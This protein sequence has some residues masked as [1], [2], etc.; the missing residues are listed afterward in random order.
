MSTLTIE[1]LVNNY[2]IP[3]NPITLEDA[4]EPLKYELL[5]SSDLKVDSEYQRLISAIAIQGYGELNRDLLATTLVSRR[6][7]SLG[8]WAG[9]FI[10][11]GQH[12]AIMHYVS[13]IETDDESTRLPCQVKVWS[14]GM[15]LE[16]IR[17]GEAKLFIKHNSERKNPTKVDIYRSG[18]LFGDPEALN[19][20]TILKNLNLVI[21]GFGS[22]EDDAI[23]L[24][25]PNP[26]FRCVL[27]DL[28]TNTMKK[29][30]TLLWMQKALK[31][32]K[33]TYFCDQN[34]DTFIHGQ[35]LR[36]FLLVTMFA[37]L[38]LTNGKQKKFKKF[39]DYKLLENYNSS[40]LIKNHGGFAGPRYI[41]HDRIID[42]Y[43]TIQ[44]NTIGKG[45]M[46]IGP[47][48]LL[49]AINVDEIFIH[50]DLL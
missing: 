12:K 50:P 26:F 35:V 41:L 33:N 2:K 8:D 25:V 14:E 47:E 32:Y 44:K 10:F 24:K 36:T 17:H 42:T 4:G 16:E 31:Q 40:A 49:Q 20:E 1:E 22:T 30:D 46:T 15:S 27:S 9:D 7:E 19:I 21:D 6:P 29:Q 37:E 45:A 23:T 5:R 18:V 38:G 13:G 48:T 39:L 3:L 11:D 34:P 43:N 28:E